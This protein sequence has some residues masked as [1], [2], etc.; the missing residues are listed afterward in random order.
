MQFPKWLSSLF[1]SF[2]GLSFLS[3]RKSTLQRIFYIVLSVVGTCII[4]V[5]S[6]TALILS[7]G[8]WTKLFNQ[9][10]AS[11]R[12]RMIPEEPEIAPRETSCNYSQVTVTMTGP[13]QRD[14]GAPEKAWY[15]S[16]HFAASAPISHEKEIICIHANASHTIRAA[17]VLVHASFQSK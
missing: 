2:W 14:K 16:Q 8:F 13:K 12:F 10:A 7:R 9:K 3:I 15:L 5:L 4:T 6:Q 17:P 11:S 1:Q